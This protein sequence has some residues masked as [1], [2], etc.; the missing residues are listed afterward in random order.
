M[1]LN[2]LKRVNDSEGHEAGDALL[3]QAAESIRAVTD[4]NTFGFRMGGDEFLIVALNVTKEG[5]LKLLHRWQ[6]GLDKAN[7]TRKRP[8]VV[9]CGMAYGE[10]NYNFDALMS[11]ADELM[12]ENKKAIKAAAGMKPD[13]R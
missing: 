3:A 10:G 4:F 7:E 13:E 2:F 8:C 1:D 5:A 11:E 6:E 9:A 12:Y